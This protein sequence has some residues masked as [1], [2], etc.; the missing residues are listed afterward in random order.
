MLQLQH[1]PAAAQRNWLTLRRNPAVYAKGKVAHAVH[2]TI[3]LLGRRQV[4]PKTKNQAPWARLV[5]FFGLTTYSSAAVMPRTQSNGLL[6]EQTVSKA[7]GP[8]S[9]PGVAAVPMW[10]EGERHRPRKSDHAGATP[11]IGSW[12]S[13][14][15]VVAML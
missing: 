6:G 11:A 14:L 12:P 9:N 2:A 7:V 4:L 10:L 13:G 15:C 3:H 8:G 1:K 5:A